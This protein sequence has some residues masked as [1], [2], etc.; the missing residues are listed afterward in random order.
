MNNLLATIYESFFD[1][2]SYQDLLY[3]VYD[4]MDYVKFGW[5]LLLIPGVLLFL[6]YKIWDPVTR[7]Q[8]FKYFLVLF[9]IFII[10]Y[11]SVS[12]ILYS[13]SE[14]LKLLGNYTGEPGQVSPDWFILQMGIIS[15]LFSAIM[16]IIYSL[17]IK[18]FSINNSH[19]PF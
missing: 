18:R 1:Y 14:I 13:N 9:L 10:I 12:G 4:Q 7:P 8:R 15:I 16:S 2:I 6:F 19:N 3:A 17:I 11:S 5:I